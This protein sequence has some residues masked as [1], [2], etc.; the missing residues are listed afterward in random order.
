MASK[1]AHSNA[2]KIRNNKIYKRESQIFAVKAAQ[3]AL[4]SAPRLAFV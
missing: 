2:A 4:I 1:A 3:A